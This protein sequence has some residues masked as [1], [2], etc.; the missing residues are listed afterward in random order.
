M[1]STARITKSRSCWKD[2]A[3][4]VADNTFATPFHQD[5]LKLGADL[6]IHSATKGLG[7]TTI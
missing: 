3:I 1:T 2:G 5:P 7:G 4:L 6:V